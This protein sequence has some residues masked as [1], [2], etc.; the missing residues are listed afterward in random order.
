[1]PD[2]TIT[3]YGH[4]RS[5]NVYKVALMLALTNTP[6]QLNLV[7]LPG[8]E[9]REDSFKTLNPFAKVP[10]L[11]DGDLV[12]RQSNSILLHLAAKTGQFGSSGSENRMRISEWLFWDQDIMFTGIGRTRFLSK[13]MNVDPVITDFLRTLGESAMTTLDTALAN[14]QWLTGDAPTIADIAIYS[15]AR[16]AEQADIDL[17]PR[18][19]V[20]AW[21]ERMEA[22]P[23]WATP[24]ALIPLD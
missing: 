4:P 11:S 14:S 2:A 19:H 16:L 15:Y 20:R 6:Y 22:L 13:V 1:M 17:E 21:R 24:E 12:I 7:D 8:G 5:G 18:P 10:V 9:Q 3:L 23:G